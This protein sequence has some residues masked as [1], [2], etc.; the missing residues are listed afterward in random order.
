MGL[1]LKKK[2]VQVEFIDSTTNS[3]LGIFEMGADLL[4]ENFAQA[5]TFD[6][7]NQKWKVVRADPPDKPGFL[8]TGMLQI[9]LSKI[10]ASPTQGELF[11]HPTT[12]GEIG[13]LEISNLPSAET[14][15][16]HQNDWRQIE[17]IRGL[18]L[19]LIKEEFEDIRHIHEY[20][21]ASIGFTAMHTRKRIAQPLLGVSI[22]ITDLRKAL[23]PI[24]EYAALSYIDVSGKV[25]LSFAWS[26]DRDFF[27][28]GITDESGS[29]TRLCLTGNPG[30]KKMASLAAAF[31]EIASYYQLV[32]VDWCQVAAISKSPEAF[33]SYFQGEKQSA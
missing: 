1:F 13:A 31:Y 15:A 10:L 8:K 28:W 17:F 14:F 32:F 6:L 9:S 2:T 24:S 5:G 25:P 16:I 3:C 19:P 20:E 7:L 22:R 11:A 26:L 23:E 4:P 33:M 27:I 18:D 30:H 29:V 21:H 12:S